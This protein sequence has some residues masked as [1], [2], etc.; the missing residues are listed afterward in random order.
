MKVFTVTE[1]AIVMVPEIPFLETLFV[2]DV[3]AL[4]LMNFLSPE[5][6]LEA[7]DTVRNDQDPF[8]RHLLT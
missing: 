5:N 8:S 6:R 2:K 7:D 1:G 4:E 3:Q